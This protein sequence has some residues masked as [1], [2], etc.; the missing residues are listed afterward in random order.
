MS[1]HIVCPSLR[2]AVSALLL[3]AVFTNSYALSHTPLVDAASQCGTVIPAN[4]FPSGFEWSAHMPTVNIYGRDEVHSDGVLVQ[5]RW[6]QMDEYVRT[7][8][9][10]AAAS[11]VYRLEA[12]NRRA[13]ISSIVPIPH[14][15]DEAALHTG[16][17]TSSLIYKRALVLVREG[18][19]YF[20]VSATASTLKTAITLAVAHTA[21]R[22]ACTS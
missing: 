14:L 8:R 6:G 12:S 2:Y 7:F 21:I 4:A 19:S 22:A 11:A 15:G 17:D 5:Y 9:T 20:E 1:R 16:H 3:T 13:G 18:R 10:T